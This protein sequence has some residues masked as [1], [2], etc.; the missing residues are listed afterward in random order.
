MISLECGGKTCTC[1]SSTSVT[2]PDDFKT[3]IV[4]TLR[5]L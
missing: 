5:R 1:V 4:G 3:K 2:G